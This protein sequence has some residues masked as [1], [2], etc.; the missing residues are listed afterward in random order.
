MVALTPP[1]LK[2]NF[3]LNFEKQ[4]YQGLH[5]PFIPKFGLIDYGMVALTPPPLHMYESF[6]MS[7]FTN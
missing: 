6:L 2:L 7:Q 4:T 1:P 3:L 5:M